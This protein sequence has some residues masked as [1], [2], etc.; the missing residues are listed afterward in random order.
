[1]RGHLRATLGATVASAA[2]ADVLIQRDACG[3]WQQLQRHNHL[4][5]PSR[6]DAAAATLAA[7]AAISAAAAAATHA[8]GR[9]AS[10]RAELG[11]ELRCRL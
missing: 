7:G 11:L 1:M 6:A 9:A 3:R 8:D 10:S 5:R 2:A 4:H